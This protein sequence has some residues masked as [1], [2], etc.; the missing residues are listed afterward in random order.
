MTDTNAHDRDFIG[1]VF[2]HCV[3]RRSSEQQSAERSIKDVMGSNETPSFVY[4]S[5]K[6]HR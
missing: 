3:P 4:S 2:P 5:K 6:K 1:R